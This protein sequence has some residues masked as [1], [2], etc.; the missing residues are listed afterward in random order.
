MQ[1][2]KLASLIAIAVATLV[3]ATPMDQRLDVRNELETRC[4][5]CEQCA[6]FGICSGCKRSEFEALGLRAVEGAK[7]ADE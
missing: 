2:T 1:F 7:F 4:C 5:T 6:R 3:A